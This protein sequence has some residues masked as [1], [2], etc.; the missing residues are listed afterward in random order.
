MGLGHM[1]NLNGRQ[2]KAKIEKD[3]QGE[4]KNSSV[5]SEKSL[6]WWYIGE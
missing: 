6:N 4:I 3:G 1:I 2:K 5:T